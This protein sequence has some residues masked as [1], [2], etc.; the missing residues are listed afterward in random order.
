MVLAVLMWFLSASKCGVSEK[1]LESCKLVFNSWLTL[2]LLAVKPWANYG[3]ILNPNFLICVKK[4]KESSPYRDTVT[5]QWDHA[6]GVL[7]FWVHSSWF[8]IEITTRGWNT[9]QSFRVVQLPWPKAVTTTIYPF[10][11]TVSAAVYNSL[12]RYSA[13]QPA[14]VLLCWFWFSKSRMGPEILHI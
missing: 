12:S 5:M 14:G 2:Y 6:C 8:Y 7:M 9:H 1:I 3:T 10:L 13:G 4:I 11:P